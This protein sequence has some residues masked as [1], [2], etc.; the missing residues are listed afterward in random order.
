MNLT[1]KIILTTIILFLAFQAGFAHAATISRPMHN[2][3]LVGYWSM[4]EGVGIDVFDRSGNVNHGTT[5]GMDNFNWVSG[6]HGGALE[7]DGSD[8]YVDLPIVS[9][10][11]PTLVTLSVWARGDKTNNTFALIVADDGSVDDYGIHIK[12]SGSTRRIKYQI[13]ASGGIT[14]VNHS[15][16]NG[17]NIM[18]DQWNHYAL[19]YDGVVSTLYFNGASI[20]SDTTATGNILYPNV[21]KIA[22]AR[23]ADNYF[24]GLIDE[25][26]IYN[27]ALS[28][29]EVQRLYNLGRPRLGV[30]PKNRLT[31]G[32]VGYWTFDGNDM[33]PNVLDVSGQGNHGDI[34]GQTSTTTAIGKVG[35]ALEFDNSDDYV[36]TPTGV[37]NLND[38]ST[39]MWFKTNSTDEYNVLMWEGE[40]AGNGGG[41]HD[42]IDIGVGRKTITV[43][44]NFIYVH[45]EQE[46]TSDVDV[47]DINLEKANFTDTDGWHHL[48]LV[49]TDANQSTPTGSLYVDGVLEDTDTAGGAI[50]YGTWDTNLRIGRVGAAD[51]YFDGKIDEVRIYNRA[52]SAAEVLELYNLTKGSD[53]NK[54]KKNR[55][56]DGLVGHWTF[57]GP[58]TN[59]VSAA[60]SSG[61]GNDGTL[62]GGPVPAIGKVGQAL[63][64]DGVDDVVVISGEGG[65]Y[66]IDI[67]T[68][69]AW[70]KR[71]LISGNQENIIDNRDGLNDGWRMNLE[72]D[73]GLDCEYDGTGGGADIEIAPSADILAGTWY[74]IACVSDGSNLRSYFNGKPINTGDTSGA[75]SISETTDLTI[76]DRSAS[77]GGRFDG[78]IDEVRI[79]NRA[80]SADEITALYNMG[81]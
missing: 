63:D 68:V 24:G 36:Q 48:V 71:D 23:D 19:T 1:T 42:E 29:D 78:K 31:N 30:S 37:K 47:A 27:R 76:G 52:L 59:T 10:L 20:N 28:A 12:D 45:I 50:P 58:D 79:Y 80:L 4:D 34:V 14:S 66:S 81:R 77:P 74:H 53:F 40:A 3:G 44:D 8:D 51:R 72:T 46:G 67:Y 38:F 41:F 39:S 61:Q 55:I 13:N 17:D 65:G 69:S 22:I 57:D 32:L 64:F 62:S 21:I 35:Q 75:G 16:D 56:T 11:E 33:V 70:I 9:T 6:Q 15:F 5:T 60:D 73:D 2:A 54:T 49:V 43:A 26:R 25:V 7:F 18:S